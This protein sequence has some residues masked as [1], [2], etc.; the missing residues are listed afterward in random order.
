MKQFSAFSILLFWFGINA[1]Q[2]QITE[3]EPNNAINAANALPLGETM[4]GQ[5]CIWNNEDWYQVVLPEDGF[6]Q[7]T[8]T[9]AGA[10]DNPAV[11]FQFQL[12]SAAGN[13]WNAFAPTAGEFGVMITDT[14]GW[15]CL[16]AGTFY[17]QVYSGYAFD[18]CYDYE[19]TLDLVPASFGNDMEPN[20]SLTDQLYVVPYNTAVEGHVSFISDPQ[21]FGTDG[22]DYYK[23]VP[24][25][26]GL[27]RL[28]IENEAQSTGS[29]NLSVMLYNNNGNPWYQQTTPIGQFQTPNSD[30]LYWECTPSDTL[31]VEIYNTNY[32]DRGYAYRFRYDMVAPLYS[33]DVEPNNTTATAQLI[34]IANPTMGNLFYYGDNGE[35]IF[36]FLK[37]DTGFFKVRV[38]SS[39]NSSD[40]TLGTKLM[41][42]D[43][44]FNLVNFVTAPLGVNGAIG[45]DS[46]Y[47]PYLAADTFYV[48]VTSDYAYAA[49]RSYILEFDYNAVPDHVNERLTKGL[50]LYPNPASSHFF[51]DGRDWIG[52]A[53]FVLIN[54]LGDVVMKKQWTGNGLHQV[55]CAGFLRGMYVAMV[56]NGGTFYTQRVVIG[57]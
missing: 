4:T 53:E 50:T 56:S 55:D 9:S 41:V 28:F 7:I 32:Y 16:K 2:A 8:V 5:V 6:L 43:H 19:V 11:P 48:R 14:A 42:M 20:S 33:D 54:S 52:N 49:C 21:S 40:G 39:T 35:D 45:M 34:D 44:N 38:S 36:K 29:G 46:L 23:I 31:I 22:H 3:S 18:Y 13:P 51:I 30:T 25:I 24:P 27:M 10:G 1:L 17:L 47:F 12:Y 26:N 37:P 15:C 57:E